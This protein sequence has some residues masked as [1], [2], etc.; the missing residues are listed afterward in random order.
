MASPASSEPPVA[1]APMVVVSGRKTKRVNRY[2]P[3]T[4]SVAVTRL[5]LTR[6]TLA[7]MW[8]DIFSVQLSNSRFQRS[9]F[10]S[11]FFFHSSQ[12]RA[13]SPVALS[14]AAPSSAEM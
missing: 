12:A 2:N 8:H 6:A 9:Y 7:G 11:A 13:A 3:V 1:S 14:M 10:P 5:R 4:S